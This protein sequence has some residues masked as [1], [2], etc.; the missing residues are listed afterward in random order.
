VRLPVRRGPARAAA[1]AAAALTVT[2]VT[3]AAVT[4][5]QGR[6]SCAG[7]D[8]GPALR[9]SA[10]PGPVG[11]SPLAGKGS[12]APDLPAG[13]R[14]ALQPAQADARLRGRALP[15]NQWWTSALTGPWTQPL[16]AH[17]LAVRATPGGMEVAGARVRALPDSVQSP[18]RP[19]LTVG[20]AQRAVRVAD[21]GAFSVRLDSTLADG[22]RLQTTVVQGSPVL[23][24]RFHGTQPRLVTG[25]Q[26]E[27]TDGGSRVRVTTE[28]QR[29]DAVAAGSGRWQQSGPELR[30]DGGGADAVLAVGAV[31]D[32]ADSGWLP[33]LRRTAAD[34]V[35]STTTSTSYDGRRGQV[36]QR[37]R[38][39][40]EHGSGGSGPFAL[41]PHQQRTLD[42]EGDGRA[43]IAAQRGAE[44]GRSQAIGTPGRVAP[45]AGS[46]A[47]PLGTLRLLGT[48]EVTLRVPMPG[49]LPGAPDLPAPSR[50]AVRADLRAD[51]AQQ[52]PVGERGLP[53]R[54]GSYFGL[55]EL[56]RLATVA[57][58]A[59]RVGDATAAREAQRR[60]RDQMVDWLTYTG[61]GDAR[62]F[63]YDRTWGGLVAVPAEFG[64]QDYND[65]N[66]QYGYLVR[67]AAALAAA[68]PQFA[69]DY[70][71]VVDLVARDYTGGNARGLPAERAFN[72][73]QGHSLASG[74]AGFLDGNNQESSSEAVA[75]W[76]AVIRWGAVTG[77]P[78]LVATGVQRYALEALTARM[79]WL[80]DGLTRPRGYAHRSAGVVWDNKIDFATFFDGRPESVLG[81]QLLPL[82]FGSL[83]RADAGSARL[84]A[85]ELTR[86]GANPPR[87]WADLFAADLAAADPP[88][89]AARLTPAMPRE[90]STSRAMVRGYVALLAAYGPPD[91]AVSADS[92]YGMALRGPHGLHLLAVNPTGQPRTVVFR[93]G[94]QVVGQLSVPP[95]GARTVTA[96]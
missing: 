43:S 19:A 28:G 36:V 55:K 82:T 81:I 30:L 53:T 9:L 10:T 44:R 3:V 86:D 2:A 5:A 17:P 75:A 95:G 50:P 84:R 42:R 31:P 67:A 57:E 70:G 15:T 69:R 7:C 4:V 78:E 21:Y 49:L 80:G 41:L 71:P 37:L 8:A 94:E 88:A 52:A 76:E 1:A 64:S 48:D 79:Y 22:G 13:S 85:G 90:P 12:I 46:Y 29:F 66:F 60:L 34:P 27:L 24:L 26:A 23:F 18:F 56:G 72:P 32:G 16:Y 45:L 39:E 96:G 89:A 20:G 74:F 73:Y 33:A 83:Y 92:P 14:P 47:E 40:R 93:R 25:G 65:H 54:G 51:L 68:D 58:L 61:P 38:F 6:G 87:I 59:A 35:T 77:Q 63:G 91:P 11:L 62:Y